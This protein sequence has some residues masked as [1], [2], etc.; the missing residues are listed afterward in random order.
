MNNGVQRLNQISEHFKI[1]V[2]RPTRIGL[3]QRMVGLEIAERNRPTARRREGARAASKPR[4]RAQHSIPLAVM[5]QQ[6]ELSQAMAI[7]ASSR[8]RSSGPPKAS[9]SCWMTSLEPF[10]AHTWRQLSPWPR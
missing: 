4:R 6:D 8:A 7:A 2:E 3:E 10:A 5:L 9:S 1:A